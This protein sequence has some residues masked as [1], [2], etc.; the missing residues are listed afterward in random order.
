MKVATAMN[1]A[2]GANVPANEL[3][4]SSE[5]CSNSKSDVS[6]YELHKSESLRLA[7]LATLPE[8]TKETNVRLANGYSSHFA[9]EFSSHHIDE[10]SSGIDGENISKDHKKEKHHK[11]EKSKKSESKK[12]E[13]KKSH[14]KESHKKERK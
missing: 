13:K 4:E 14:K 8:S 12:S 7:I 10:S 3:V 2:S 9:D 11:G 6:A 5:T 1:G